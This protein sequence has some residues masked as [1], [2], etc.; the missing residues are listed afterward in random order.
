[1]VTGR[2]DIRL[3]TI[4]VEDADSLGIAGPDDGRLNLVI[5]GGRTCSL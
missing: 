2:R 1:M 3:R 5:L 4:I